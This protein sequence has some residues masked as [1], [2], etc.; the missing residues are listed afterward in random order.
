ML[1]SR[2]TAKFQASARGHS[3]QDTIDR[4]IA[5]HSPLKRLSTAPSFHP[6][7]AFTRV[8]HTW[9][10]AEERE[11]MTAAAPSGVGEE[12]APHGP[13]SLRVSDVRLTDLQWMGLG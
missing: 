7:L 12:L 1:E 10:T 5:D 6:C 8:F 3:W 9:L 2:S 13:G 11:R 4:P